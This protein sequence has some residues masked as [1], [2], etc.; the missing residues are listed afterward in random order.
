MTTPPR[1]LWLAGAI[2]LLTAHALLFEGWIVDDAGISFAYARNLA[3]GHGLV[4]QPGVPPVEGFSN[5]LWVLVLA[6]LLAAGLFHPVLTPKILSLALLAVGASLLHRSL[7]H[8]TR[9]RTVSLL[10]LA[11]LAVCTPFVAWGVSGLENPLYA[12][13]LCGLLWRIVRDREKGSATG[14][15][16][17]AAAALAA[18][19]AL[20][21]P[22]G[23][24]FAALYPLL[25]LT[26][27][28][29][30]RRQAVGRVLRYAA[31]FALLLGAFLAFRW[32]YFGDLVPNTYYAKVGP[33]SL[34]HELPLTVSKILEP[35]EAAAGPAG[36]PLLAALLAGTAWLIARR[37]FRGEHGILLA[38]AACGLLPYLLLPR[39]WMGEYRFATPFFPFLYAYTT[40]LGAT[41]GAARIPDPARRRR[42]ALAASAAAVALALLLFAPRSLRFAAALTVPFQDV[43]RLFGAR[44]NRF[45]D[46][47]GVRQGSILLPD[48]GGALWASRLRVYDLAGL[49]DRTIARTV[50]ADLAAFHD[51]VF[52]RTKPVFIHCHAGWTLQAA[53]D[54]DP[55][56]ERD[57]LALYEVVEPDVRARA[58]RPLRS[59]DFVRRDAAAGREA[60]VAILRAELAEHYARQSAPR[61]E[62]R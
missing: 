27:V 48:V 32:S 33:Q 58:G 19:A 34:R 5:F 14:A 1:R 11:L 20:T 38:F 42:P 23:L 10:P 62:K 49:A 47:L 9:S 53:L 13:L 51:Y 55:R 6:P 16:P 57:Y 31:G 61:Q 17:W 40:A 56:F 30:P 35:F 24:V 45:A 21:R 26:A 28:P 36:L 59:G 41:L 25:T 15:S 7:W 12:A 54:T 50:D 37:R 18:G 4:S 52:E 44:Y 43:V 46:S 22:D 39:D 60:A 29:L 8:L 3:A 2:L